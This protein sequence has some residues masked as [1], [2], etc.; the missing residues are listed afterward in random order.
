V[1]SSHFPWDTSQTVR[2]TQSYLFPLS[3]LGLA[4]YMFVVGME[5]RLDIVRR[6]WRSSLAVS[7]AG[8]LAPF[9]LGAGLA[10]MLHRHTQHFPSRTPLFEAMLFLGASMCITAFPMLA[11]IIHYK[12]LTGTK[13]GTVAIGAG[14][15]DDATAWC[16]LAAGLARNSIPTPGAFNGAS[17]QPALLQIRQHQR[18]PRQVIA[19][20]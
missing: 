4:L 1:A 14:A 13:M 6:H 17:L 9:V 10:W 19:A 2:D 18:V 12:G 15:I 16:L 5:F 8:M 3:Q 11:R 7:V 20:S